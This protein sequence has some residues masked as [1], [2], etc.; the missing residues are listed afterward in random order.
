V[1]STCKYIFTFES[2]AVIG[3]M[4]ARIAQLLATEKVTVINF[5]YP[6]RFIA[7]GKISEL[8]EEIGFTA[9]RLYEKIIQM[10]K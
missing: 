10:L 1:A 2:N 8:L 4:G 9:P 5:G 6:D 3:G 7:Q